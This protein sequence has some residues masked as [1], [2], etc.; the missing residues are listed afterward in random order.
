[1]RSDEVGGGGAR[2]LYRVSRTSG[3]ERPPAADALQPPLRCGFR[4]RLRRGDQRRASVRSTEASDDRLARFGVVGST[5]AAIGPNER[6]L[7]PRSLAWARR[8]R[9]ELQG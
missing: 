1:M 6:V 4:A 5:R 7:R 2:R 9:P 3:A 8:I